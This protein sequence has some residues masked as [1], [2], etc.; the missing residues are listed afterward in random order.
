MPICLSP[1][2]LVCLVDLDGPLVVLIPDSADGSPPG[3]ALDLRPPSCSHGL[4]GSGV[5]D[6]AAGEGNGLS[7]VTWLVQVPCRQEAALM[8]ALQA[9]WASCYG[10]DGLGHSVLAGGC[11]LQVPCSSGSGIGSG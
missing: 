8:T 9:L 4:P 10:A 1:S 5:C 3:V 2:P 6:Q 7:I 11:D